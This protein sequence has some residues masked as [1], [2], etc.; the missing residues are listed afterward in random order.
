[1]TSA[2]STPRRSGLLACIASKF[3]SLWPLD[4]SI[5]A[6]AMPLTRIPLDA[7]ARAASSVS[8]ESA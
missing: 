1:M 5:K 4:R 3:S 2:G 7:S 6:G 8:A